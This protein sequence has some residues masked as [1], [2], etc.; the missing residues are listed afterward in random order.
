[1][2]SNM[3]YKYEGW[4]LYKKEVK[5]YTG[6]KQSIYFF[7]RRKPKSGTPCDLPDGFIVK[8]LNNTGSRIPYIRRK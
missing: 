8:R 4:S 1:M 3:V 6:K 2:V 5:L 7:S